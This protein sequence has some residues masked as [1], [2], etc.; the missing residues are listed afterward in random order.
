MQTAPLV[1]VGGEVQ[2]PGSFPIMPGMT[3]Q[4]AIVQAGDIGPRGARSKARVLRDG[5]TVRAKLSDLVLPG[6]Q[7]LVG[8]R[9]F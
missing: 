6:D 4:Q 1:Y 9:I 7:I 8:A 5:Q 2:R 3:V